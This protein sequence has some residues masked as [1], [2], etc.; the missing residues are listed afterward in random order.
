MF[1][2]E[3]LASLN[4]NKNKFLSPGLKNNHTLKCCSGN[5]PTYS[6]MSRLLEKYQINILMYGY[7]QI[8]KT[9]SKQDGELQD[10]SVPY[11]QQESGP[12][13]LDW[14]INILSNVDL[15]FFQQ[16]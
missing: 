4:F 2:S 9:R 16:S 11:F 8:Q 15:V 12:W 1:H 5:F 13:P 7:S 14:R 10:K 3:I 6:Y